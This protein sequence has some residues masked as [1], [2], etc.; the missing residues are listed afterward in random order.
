M[1]TLRHLKIK[2]HNNKMSLFKERQKYVCLAFSTNQ[3]QTLCEKQFHEW[4]WV[5]EHKCKIKVNIFQTL[6]GQM[7]FHYQKCKIL[8]KHFMFHIKCGAC[9]KAL[10]ETKKLNMKK[11]NTFILFLTSYLFTFLLTKLLISCSI[12]LKII[13]CL[14]RHVI[15]LVS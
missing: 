6:Q 4:N 9:L 15:S 5:C 13:K 1:W 14:R 11:I 2:T 12:F 8:Q 3:S 7:A 10:L